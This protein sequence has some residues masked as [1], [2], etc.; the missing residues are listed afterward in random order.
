MTKNEQPAFRE[1][2]PNPTSED[3]WTPAAGGF[4]QVEHTF[5]PAH[6]FQLRRELELIIRDTDPDLDP[7]SRRA[8]AERF[9]EVDLINLSKLNARAL[10]AEKFMSGAPDPCRD[11]NCGYLTA[12][13]HGHLCGHL[14]DCGKG[15]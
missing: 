12:H 11:T 1:A 10:A 14:C 2:E 9:L 15:D 5:T 8:I 7:R 4:I 13:E 3:P 6:V